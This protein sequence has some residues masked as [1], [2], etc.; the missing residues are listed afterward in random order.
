MRDYFVSK[1]FQST[2]ADC[3]PIGFLG[4]FISA[5]LLPAFS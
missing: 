3:E 1:A 4:L 5:T 2:P